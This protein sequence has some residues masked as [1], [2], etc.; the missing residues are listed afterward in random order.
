MNRRSI[1]FKD[2]WAAPGSQLHAALTDG[3]KKLALKIYHE[4]DDAQ[5]KLEGR[6]N[7]DRWTD[8]QASA[9]YGLVPTK[10]SI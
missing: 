10:E 3:N 6:E 7:K 5:K 2:T 8:E 4:C 1:Q 9:F